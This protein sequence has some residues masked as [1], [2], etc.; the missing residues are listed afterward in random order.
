VEKFA[1]MDLA[2]YPG[3]ECTLARFWDDFCFS[4]IDNSALGV[5][6]EIFAFLYAFGG[7]AISAD[8]M[9][10]S[11]ETICDHWGIPEDVGG[12]TLMAFGSA[13][14]EI[15]VN[16]ISTLR[17][18]SASSGSA[19]ASPADLGVGAILGSGMIAFLIIPSISALF[20]P[21]GAGLVLKRR[22]L[23]RDMVAYGAALF[24]LIHSIQSGGPSLAVSLALLGV[25]VTYIFVLVFAR[26]IRKCLAKKKGTTEVERMSSFRERY[27]NEEK[28]F[29]GSL[30]GAD[31][32]KLAYVPMPGDE[33]EEKEENTTLIEK[34][35]SFV[36]KPVEKS[37]ELT[38]PD[39]RINEPHEN[40][41]MVTFVVSFL[42]ITFY[43]SVVTVIANR[44]VAILDEPAAMGF[45]GLVI[46]ALG[47]E[48]PDTVNAVTVAKRGYGAMSTASCMGSQVVNICIGLGL[49]WTISTALHFPVPLGRHD[50]FIHM[51]SYVQ[52]GNLMFVA[53]VILGGALTG[54]IATVSHRKAGLFGC[55][56]LAL[57]VF[58]ALCT[59]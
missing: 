50:N 44:F 52:L 57:I 17:A 12:A 51:A 54:G 58:F 19:K 40:W 18:L 41:Y 24:L 48:I 31:I 2:A 3:V 59:F 6:L 26:P 25:Y 22:P 47:A 13:I 8:P 42:W 56:Y 43:S 34:I 36:F 37:I 10:N 11:M 28:S 39:C 7:L 1:V 49:P 14:P 33:K 9:V 4:C 5:G 32:S 53:V 46:V 45:F 55:V 23:L 29:D 27:S 16:A 21:D 20:S 15:T 35:L 38:C 30:D